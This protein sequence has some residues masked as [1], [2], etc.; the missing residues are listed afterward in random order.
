MIINICLPIQFYHASRRT[1]GAEVAIMGVFVVTAENSFLPV[2][3][4]N[5]VN[6]YSRISTVP[7]G[8]ER[9]E[10]PG[11][12]FK[13]RSSLTRNAPLET[14]QIK[15]HEDRKCKGIKHANQLLR[16]MRN[17]CAV[18]I[19]LNW[20]NEAKRD[21]NLHQTGDCNFWSFLIA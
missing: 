15:C 17:A 13:T 20:D 5:S 1:I 2:K 11:G 3:R 21:R 10:R 12:P 8:S 7:W 6:T 16:E 14:W 18:D 9:S 19:V 4:D